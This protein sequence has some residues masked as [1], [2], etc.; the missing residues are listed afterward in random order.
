MKEAVTYGM[1]APMNPLN[2]R[3]KGIKGIKKNNTSPP[4]NKRETPR[5]S[6]FFDA[7]DLLRAS[8]L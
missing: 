6:V 3:C 8:F 7:R 4:I 1:C 2:G 5:T